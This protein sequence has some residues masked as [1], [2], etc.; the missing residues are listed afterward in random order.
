MK[1]LKPI[2]WWETNDADFNEIKKSY[3]LDKKEKLQKIE[4]DINSSGKP[5]G[6]I[7]VDRILLKEIDFFLFSL[8]KTPHSKVLE[9][10][11]S[12]K[13]PTRQNFSGG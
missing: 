6:Y 4:W 9:K 12:R 10:I 5:L 13:L 11:P 8:K 1:K 3:F 2:F 7:K